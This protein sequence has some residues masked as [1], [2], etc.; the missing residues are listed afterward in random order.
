V[1]VQ[2]GQVVSPPTF[3]AGE[4]VRV[5]AKQE[6]GA[7]YAVYVRLTP[8]RP[9]VPHFHGYAGTDVSYTAGSQLVITDKK[10]NTDTFTLDANTVFVQGF[11]VVTNPTITNGEHL[12]VWAVV[13]PATTLD[14]K[15]VWLFPPRV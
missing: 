8:P 7:W 13:N 6:A 9:P 2:G 1:F 3:V 4:H 5:W 14:A 12:S 10:G 11:K 15:V